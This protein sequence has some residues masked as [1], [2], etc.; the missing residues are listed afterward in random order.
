MT[1]SDAPWALAFLLLLANSMSFV[2][3]M[4]LT[5]MVGP[6]RA[7]LGISDTQISLLHGF[8]FAAFYALAGLP[9]GKLA[10]TGHRPRLMS[11]GTGAWSAMTAVCG[12][13][14][15]FAWM[16]LARTGVAVGEASLSPAAVSLLAERFRRT[17]A[18]RAIAVFQS[19]IFIGTGLAMLGGGALLAW[20]TTHADSLPGGLT[21][22]RAVF[23]TVALPG[24]PIAL[25]LLAVREPRNRDPRAAV[26]T[27][28]TREALRHFRDHSRLYGGHLLAFTAITVLAYG[29]LSW[30]PS[31]LVRAHAMPISEAGQLL[32]IVL[33]VGGPLGVMASGAL[34]DVFARR[35][36]ASGPTLTTLLAAAL[37][38]IAAPIYG[39]ADDVKT[40][41]AAAF[42]L[43]FAQS[44]PYGIASAMLAIVA[45]ARL[46]ARLVALYLM[47]SNLVGLS[48]GPLLIAL[49]T[50]H[51]FGDDA[52]VGTSLA[53]LPILT[54]PLALAGVAA[55]WLPYRRAWL[56]AQDGSH[57]RQ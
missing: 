29:S 54:T 23:V 5:L 39:L 20:F 32:G 24:L 22:W 47:V 27:P 26:S 53:L 44:F 36:L 50:E 6:I 21:P 15:S 52:S 51:W 17:L 37:L 42:L 4:L 41:T 18:S 49:T 25:L 16:F 19:G 28:S 13:A 33:L 31:V 45:P 40:A 56:H 9:L 11:A 34:L 14:P 35:G 57:E 7:E 55:C 30:M 38:A 8:A 46:R 2:D 3:R 12:L 48:L 43:A 1:K 10:D